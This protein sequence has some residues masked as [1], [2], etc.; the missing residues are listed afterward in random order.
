MLFIRVKS[1]I[2]LFGLLLLQ[3]CTSPPTAITYFDRIKLVGGSAPQAEEIALI[4][5]RKLN[6][7]FFTINLVNEHPN[8]HG[9]VR[10][11]KCQLW[12]ASEDL[13]RPTSLEQKVLQT[14][15]FSNSPTEI[16]NALNAWVRH[17]DGRGGAQPDIY[18]M[19][20]NGN[21]VGSKNGTL[22]I[23]FGK[24]SFR[25]ILIVSGRYVAVDKTSVHL[26]IRTFSSDSDIE[27]FS[28][29]LYQLLF[30]QIAQELF[31]EAIKL[32]PIEMK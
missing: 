27:V 4:E 22:Q 18:T 24:P 7:F 31:T 3:A 30:N 29:K 2:A 9:R 5:C 23:Q 25:P 11:Y 8:I 17:K 28:P 14:R 6:P 10:D 1:L 12:E 19:F 21:V 20:E 13:T 32:E 26:Q 16:E 15:K